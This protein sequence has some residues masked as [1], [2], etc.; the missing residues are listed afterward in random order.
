MIPVVF[1]RYEIVLLNYF[2]L[3]LSSFWYKER[4]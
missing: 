2:T 3:K 4:N 1:Y